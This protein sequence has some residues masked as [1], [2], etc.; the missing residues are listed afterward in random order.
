MRGGFREP[1]HFSFHFFDSSCLCNTQS[2]EICS[3]QY[4]MCSVSKG[5]FMK[6]FSQ[7]QIN[8]A[9]VCVMCFLFFLYSQSALSR[10]KVN[11]SREKNNPL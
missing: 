10:I 11:K 5:K 3:V 1:L 2:V 8:A 9:S 6:K 7:R 4:T